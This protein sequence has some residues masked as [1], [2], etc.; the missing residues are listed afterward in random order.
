MKL[1]SKSVAAEVSKL[2]EGVEFET[3][4]THSAYY[5]AE[6]DDT[7]EPQVGYIE[8]LD[9]NGFPIECEVVV[10]RKGVTV[11]L[12]ELDPEGM[13]TIG[14]TEIWFKEGSSVEETTQ[15]ASANLDG[16]VTKEQLVKLGF[17]KQS[18]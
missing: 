16:S 12:N 13:Q 14:D 11:F 7:G 1:T 4:S 15:Y 9:S 10:D 6:G 17:T 2:V 3:A 5:G 18:Y 8:V